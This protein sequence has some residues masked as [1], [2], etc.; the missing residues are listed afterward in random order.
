MKTNKTPERWAYDLSTI[1]TTVLGKDRFPVDAAGLAKEYSQKTCPSD[2][3]VSVEK[4]ALNECEGALGPFPGRGSDWGIEYS[5]TIDSQGR[6]NFTIAHEFG[7]YLLHRLKYPNGVKCTAEDMAKWNSK[8]NQVENEANRFAA[9]LLMPLDDFRK[10]IPETKKVDFGDLRKCAERYQVS[11]M[12]ATLRWLSYTK[13]R[14][15]LVVS[16]DG[17]ILWSRSSNPAFE[18][19]IYI[20][21]EGVSPPNEVPD[22]SPIV[23]NPSEIGLADPVSHNSDVWLGKEVV[24]HA[25]ISNR[26]DLGLSLLILPSTGPKCDT[27]EEYAPDLVDEFEGLSR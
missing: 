14:A 17:F 23:S 7:H 20:K 25:F 18:S 16:R 3:I 27:D 24:E 5:D 22:Q 11:L 15:L 9:S 2:P 8:Y 1:L 21:V 6:V 12:A 19:G 4:V 13:I 10:Q 26:Y